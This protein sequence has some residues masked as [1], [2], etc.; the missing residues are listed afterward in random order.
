LALALPDW[1]RLDNLDWRDDRLRI[2]L[3]LKMTDSEAQDR[4][5]VMQ[6]FH[7]AVDALARQM[8]DYSV[9]VTRY[10]FPASPQQSFSNT[11]SDAGIVSDAPTAE[12]VVRR[13]S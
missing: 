2:D 13:R 1:A 6:Q 9:D 12:L 10:P 3:R 5:T 11:A 8:P 4:E 7:Q